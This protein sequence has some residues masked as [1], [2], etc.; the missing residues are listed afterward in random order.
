MAEVE[1]PKVNVEI[2]EKNKIRVSTQKYVDCISPPVFQDDT[3]GTK[4]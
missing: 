4:Y 2:M 1:E 3:T